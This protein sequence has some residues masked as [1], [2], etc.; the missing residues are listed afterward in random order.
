VLDQ[1]IERLGVEAAQM[2]KDQR[3]RSVASDGGN[4]CQREGGIINFNGVEGGGLNECDAVSDRSGRR[5]SSWKGPPQ[6]R[7][8]R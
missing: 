5:V 4:R 6:N 8:T 7:E 1:R 3:R 2:G